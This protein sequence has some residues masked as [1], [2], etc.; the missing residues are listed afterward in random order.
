MTNFKRS[1]LLAGAIPA[2]L[3]LGACDAQDADQASDDVS[4]VSSPLTTV[5]YEAEAALLS[6]PVISTAHPGYT[7]TG[8][9]DYQNATGDFVEWTVNAPSAGS[10]TLAFRYANGGGTSRPLSI[11]VN[12]TVV[13]ASLAFPPT[14]GWG[15][16]STVSMTATLTAGSNK[17]RATAIGSSGGDVDN[18][19]VTP[20]ANPVLA[21]KRTAGCDVAPTQAIGQFVKYTISTSGTKAANCADSV[22]GPWTLSRDYYVWLPA[23]YDQTKAYPLVFEMSG[24]GGSGTTVYPLTSNGQPSINNSVIRVGL[25][26]PPNSIGHATNP[27]QGCYDDREGDDSVDFVF[28]QDVRDILKT[29]LCYDENRVFASGNSTGSNMA[30]QMACKYSGN[31]A[32]YALRGIATNAG[33]L[34][35]DPKYTPTCTNSPMSGMWVSQLG[36]P[37]QPFTGVKVAVNRAMAVNGCTIGTSYD[38]AQFD[39]YP[40]G[41]GNADTT[42]KIIRGCPTI[43][44]LV[45]CQLP[46]NVHAS[47]DTVANPGFSTF[48][49]AFSAP[50]FEN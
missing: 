19:Q 48:I 18:L 34:T 38:T 44:P 39:N 17:V 31:T 4:T 24:C 11:K 47:N 40:I 42:C 26:P 50:P 16:W 1:I 3:S 5:T 35:T 43:Y 29:Q 20:V 21:V 32:G 12:G 7:G 49:S 10:Y 37:I 41:G 28:Y 15:K 8:F 33:G 30:N 22:C 6:G 2:L 36:D 23:G 9:A 13:N 25:S 14:G 46:G 45:V 27:N